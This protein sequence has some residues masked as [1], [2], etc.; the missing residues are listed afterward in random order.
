MYM[1]KIEAKGRRLHLRP[2]NYIRK[3]NAVQEGLSPLE[4]LTA[5]QLIDD[6]FMEHRIE[7]S[8]KRIQV[9]GI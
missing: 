2:L 8:P 3:Q 4:K 5:A 9:W 7:F 6:K 1:Q